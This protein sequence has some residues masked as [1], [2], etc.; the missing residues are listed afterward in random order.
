MASRRGFSLILVFRF[1]FGCITKNEKPT[2]DKRSSVY[3]DPTNDSIS[4]SHLHYQHLDRAQCP[5]VGARFCRASLGRSDR[6][7]CGTT[8]IEPHR[9]LR[10]ARH[11]S[12]PHHR[13]R[14]GQA[15]AHRSA[16]NSPPPP[17]LWSAPPPSS[18]PPWV[19]GGPAP[20]PPPPDT[21]P[22]TSAPRLWGGGNYRGSM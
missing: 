21:P 12:L 9:A 18:P 20:P 14:V 11:H 19:G 15:R 3:N 22:P 17:P 7:K 13:V 4:E 8:H 16:T 6:K 5:R 1:W 10:S 2:N